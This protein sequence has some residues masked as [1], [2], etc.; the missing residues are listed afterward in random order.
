M[1]PWTEEGFDIDGFPFVIFVSV[2]PFGIPGFGIDFVE[3]HGDPR[4]RLA[5]G[6]FVTSFATSAALAT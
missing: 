3:I 6:I 4:R 1:F 2:F 5:G